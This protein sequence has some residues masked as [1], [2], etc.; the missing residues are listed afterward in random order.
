MQTLQ[1]T[2]TIFGKTFIICRQRRNSKDQMTKD[3][4]I[5]EVYIQILKFTEIIIKVSLV[6]FRKREVCEVTFNH[7]FLWIYLLKCNFW[8]LYFFQEDHIPVNIFK[9]FTALDFLHSISLLGL[10]L[11]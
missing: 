4:Q 9:P 3:I 7:M 1:Q 2:K 8:W 10:N 11:Q 6:R 5:K